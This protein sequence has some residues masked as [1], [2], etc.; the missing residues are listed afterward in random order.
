MEIKK[1]LNIEE[2]T[3]LL[4]SSTLLLQGVQKHP[5]AI[6]RLLRQNQL[7]GF[8]LDEIV[9]IVHLQNLFKLFDYIRSTKTDI[10]YSHIIT[11][12]N[13]ILQQK[14][15]TK[16]A[17]RD[18]DNYAEL[19]SQIEKSILDNKLN[20]STDDELKSGISKILDEVVGDMCI[21]DSVVIQFLFT[22]LCLYVK[23]SLVL[24]TSTTDFSDEN[25]FVEA[26]AFSFSETVGGW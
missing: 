23:D 26:E 21:Y 2:E 16:Q 5:N 19:F 4:I 17:L 13:F 1:V 18:S 11:I 15:V 3:P 24:V 14:D 6:E 8:T 22:N 20:S 7:A 12:I 9:D 10:D 25:F